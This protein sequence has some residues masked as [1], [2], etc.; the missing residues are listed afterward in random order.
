MVVRKARKLLNEQAEFANEQAQ[1]L[2]DAPGT[3]ARRA[4]AKTARTVKA[5]ERPARVATRAGVQLTSLS[6]HTLESLLELQ[7]E[8]VTSVITNAAAQLE[9]MSRSRSLRGAVGGQVEELRAARDRIAADLE[10]VIGILTRTGRGIGTVAKDAYEGV[11]RPGAEAP[12]RR[13][14]RRKVAKRVS[15]KAKAKRAVRKKARGR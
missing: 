13:R 4:A 1:V 9:R 11:V 3:L 2:R 15:R 6:Q 10:R 8:V 5:L 7:L 12:A 14:K